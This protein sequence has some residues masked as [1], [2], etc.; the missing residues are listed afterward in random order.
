MCIEVAYLNIS[1][2]KSNFFYIYIVI[3]SP[4]PNG[5]PNALLLP[6]FDTTSVVV[7]NTH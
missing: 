3:S 7:S 6:K 4:L 5:H 2:I 1:K